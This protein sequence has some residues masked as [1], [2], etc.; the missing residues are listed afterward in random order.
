VREGRTFLPEQRLMLLDLWLRS[1]L[2]AAEFAELAGVSRHTLYTWKKR[3]DRG[4]P[5]GLLGK[6]QGRPAGSR[7]PEP[8]KRAIV[9]LKR[10]HP[11]WGRQR[12]HDE[13]VRAEGLE[14]SC[15]AIG[16]V[17]QGAGYEVEEAATR[18]HPP[19]VKRFERARPN[20]L[21]QSD[22]FTF[23]LKRQ[24]RRVY[25]VAFLDDCSRFVVGH[26]LS[27]SSSGVFVRD[28]FEAAVANHGLPEEALTDRGPQY[29]TWR[30]TSAFTKLLTRRGVKHRLSRPRHPETVGK[31]ERMWKTLWEEFLREAIFK[32]LEDAR[33]RIH[34]WFDYYNFSRPHQ[35]IGGLVPADR[36]FEAAP[37]RKRALAARVAENALEIAR[38]GQPRKPFYL[39]GRVG[40]QP[41]SLHAEGD[42]VVLIR[43]DGR[44]EEVDLV[45]TG[46]RDTPLFA[47]RKDE[48]V[49]TGLEGLAAAVEE[50]DAER[51][52]IEAE[53][54]EDD[55]REDEDV[56]A[57]ASDAGKQQGGDGEPGGDAA[58]G[59]DRGDALG[60][61]EPGG[62]ERGAGDQ[63][64]PLLPAGGPGAAGA[65]AGPGALASGAA[66]DAGA[67]AGPAAGGEGAAG[68]GVASLPG[69]GADGAADDRAC[70]AQ[71]IGGRIEEATSAPGAGQDGAE[72]A[73]AEGVVGGD[74]RGEGVIEAAKAAPGGM[75]SSPQARPRKGNAGI[76]EGSRGR[77]ERRARLWK[78]WR[79]RRT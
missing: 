54:S 29:A 14:A 76:E 39:A 51:H 42:T 18:P 75:D 35:G 64:E 5:A 58:G 79:Q 71:A 69:V 78:R 74:E 19:P 8:T 61:G 50:R 77:A 62:D 46:W 38:G 17:L 41:I 21:W 44:R 53:R 28:C 48:P 9:M 65:G 20:Q 25:L 12:I 49:E 23:L 43:E 1:E 73:P 26:A 16:K 31:T 37:E 27:A 60:A 30:G 15:G 56:E 13:L 45:A 36:Y 4:G 10:S 70:Q 32:D 67:G 72:D 24:N 55:E 2:P 57:G 33:A 63:C 22:I 34:S 7:L 59:G 47:P 40:D 66:A 52:R 68:E 11:D 3:F 6:K